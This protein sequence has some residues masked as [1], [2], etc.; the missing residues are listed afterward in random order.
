MHLSLMEECCGR[1]EQALASVAAGTG[2][3]ARREMKLHAALGL[4]L[5]QTKGPTSIAVAW[6]KSLEIAES[7]D[8]AEYDCVRFGACGRFISAALSI[9]Q[10][11]N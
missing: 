9:R 8:D 2:R 3:D 6:T 5:L 11:W 10:L 1:V 7:L 4:S